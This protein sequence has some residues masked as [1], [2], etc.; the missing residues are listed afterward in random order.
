MTT[1]MTIQECVD[2]VVHCGKTNTLI[3][4]G[5][6]G[7]GKSQVG[8]I[9]TDK[10]NEMQNKHVYKHLYIDLPAW[11]ESDFQIPLIDKE[12]DTMKFVPNE[13]MLYSGPVVMLLDEIGKATPPVKNIATTL[14][15]EKRIGDFHLHPDSIVM[16][17]TNLSTDGV[18][19][20]IPAQVRNRAT[21]VHMK[22]EGAE[23]WIA[24]GMDNG[25][26]PEMLAFVKE[27]P[28]VLMSYTDYP[29]GNPKGDN[30]YI[31]DPRKAQLAFATHRSLHKASH[32]LKQREHLTQNALMA[33][34]SGTIGESAAADLRAF[35]NFADALPA[36]AAILDDPEHCE[37]P[38]SPVACMILAFG[39]VSWLDTKTFPVWM[40]YLVR[41]PK[42]VQCVWAS[43]LMLNTRCAPIAI[44]S[45]AYTDW[46]RENAVLV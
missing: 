5:Q 1:Q 18:G 41:L 39:S 14:I 33:T 17:T 11:M 32:I 2:F 38:K 12:T 46:A 34:L 43:Q 19:D 27:Y 15:N 36:R 22:G 23:G 20:N 26:V 40:K 25:I 16:A 35:I 6:P 29:E 4:Q 28:A 13:V 8:F 7:C 9:A 45:K 31:F 44:S 37:V 30:P 3:I 21:I 42:E 24:W 10:I